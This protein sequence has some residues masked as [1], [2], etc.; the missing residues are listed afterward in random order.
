MVV[1]FFFSSRRRHTR[2]LSDWSSDV[3]SSDLM[4]RAKL[5]SFYDKKDP[6]AVAT[7]WPYL[8]DKDRFLRYA[9]R[10]VLEFQDSATWQEKALSE[11]N[12]IAL[13]HALI[14]LAR[15]GD[16]SLLPKMIESLERVDWKKLSDPQKI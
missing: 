8:N 13:T 7:A 5:E 4:A 9:A 12:P 14:G 3:C 16:K 15:T 2:C 1:F 11:K 10:T 6:Q